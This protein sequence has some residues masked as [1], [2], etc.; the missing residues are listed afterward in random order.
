VNAVKPGNLIHGD[1]W[2]HSL[3]NK[4]AHARMVVALVKPAGK[5]DQSQG[6]DSDVGTTSC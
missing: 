1:G 3:Q 6:R 2:L 4:R 5:G